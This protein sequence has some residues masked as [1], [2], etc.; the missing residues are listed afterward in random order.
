MHDVIPSSSSFVYDEESI[1]LDHRPQDYYYDEVVGL[2]ADGEQDDD[3]AVALY[4]QFFEQQSKLSRDSDL[5]DAK[6]RR[7]RIA[8]AISSGP[9]SGN[10][11]S[12]NTAGTA[13]SDASSASSS[14]GEEGDA[15]DEKLEPAVY[16]IL[17]SRD[18]TQIVKVLLTTTDGDDNE[19]S[20]DEEEETVIIGPLPTETLSSSPKSPSR[21]KHKE[22]DHGSDSSN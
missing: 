12:G 4:N 18:G 16:S 5:E 17:R 10:H 8:T 21:K 2:D 19:A 9:H 7:Q 1:Y 22:F 20:K 3:D 6:E 15:L 14:S 13:A 11:S